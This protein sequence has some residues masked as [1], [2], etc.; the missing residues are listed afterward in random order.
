MKLRILGCAGAEFPDFRPPAFLI[1]D[2]LLLDAGTIS[3]VLS[4]E[5]QWNIR[6]I[7]I[8]HSHLDHIR[9]IPALADNIIL[10][11]MQHTVTVFSADEVISAIQQHMFNDIIWPDFTRIPSPENPVIALTTITPYRD[12]AVHEHMVQAIPVNH[13]VPAVGYRVQSGGRT[14][15]YSGDTGPT[16]EIWKFCSGAD[17]LIVEVSFPNCMEHLARITRHLT[18]SMLKTELSKINVLPSRILITHPKPQYYDDIQREINEI[19]V[20][21]VELLC[22]GS[23]Y[24][25]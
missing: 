11:N 4:E 1:D 12:Y 10:R 23:V 13:T 25:I 17:A 3:A 2:Q 20:H 24:D 6:S 21:G 7:F 19:G 8:T 16:V 18:S 5:E 14:L 15:V 22:D 9:A